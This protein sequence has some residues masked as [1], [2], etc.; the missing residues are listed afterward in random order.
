M[1]D[2]RI[3]DLTTT[4]TAPASD[5]FVA[6]DGATNA[7]RKLDASTLVQAAAAFGT[8]NRLLRSD[9]TG[10][11]SQAT[12]ITV[13]DSN[14]ITG[15]GD[16]SVTNLTATTFVANSFEFEGS[17][18]DANETTLGVIDPTAD[19]TINLPDASGTVALDPNTTEGDL[20]VRGSSSNQRLGIGS[21]THVLTVDTSVSGKI[22]W[23]APTGSSSYSPYA[24]VTF[25][26]DFTSIPGDI[27][28][29]SATVR[30]SINFQDGS[31]WC[32]NSA[33]GGAY[34]TSDAPPAGRAGV[35][36]YKG[37]AA[38]NGFEQ[39]SS[40]FGTFAPWYVLRDGDTVRFKTAVKIYTLADASNDFAIRLGLSGTGYGDT[41][42]FIDFYYSRTTGT[43]IGR[44]CVG[45]ST[46]TRDSSVSVVAG[47]YYNLEWSI[48]R[49]GSSYTTKFYHSSDLTGL[50][51]IG[52]DITTSFSERMMSIFGLYDFIA[53]SGRLFE[54]DYLFVESS[55]STARP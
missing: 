44:F 38:D 14:N 22:K 30:S 12:G 32:Q 5:D 17:T 50:S 55:N 29:N 42:N 49:S 10:R 31:A 8:D 25:M 28:S 3:K 33:G 40:S 6:L 16:L 21:N 47:T 39:V 9:G 37:A 48:T 1:A 20:I 54:I 15:V 13:D 46:T 34:S 2:V 27:N 41:S 24:K 53:G 45:G 23:A 4:A 36:R 51:Q 7:T 11:G 19:R 43:W 26:E 18:V 35:L 52:S